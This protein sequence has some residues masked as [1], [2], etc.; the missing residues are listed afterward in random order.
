MKQ[1]KKAQQRRTLKQKAKT[2]KAAAKTA[3]V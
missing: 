2:K 3:K 1:L